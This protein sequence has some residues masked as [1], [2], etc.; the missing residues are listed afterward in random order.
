MEVLLST[1]V[2]KALADALWL[3][4]CN[5]HKETSRNG[6][7]LVCPTPV[8]TV[9]SHPTQRVLFSPL[10]NANPFFHLM[11][12][13]WMI[14]GRNDLDWPLRFNKNFAGFSDD[15]VT[16]HGAYGH[17]WRTHFGID[18][19]MVLAEELT[20]NPNSRRAVLGMWDVTQDLGRDGKDVPCNTHVYFD[21]RNHRLNM[22]VCCRSNDI[23]W[24]AY[25]ANAVHFSILQEF[26]AAWVGIPVGVYRQMSNNLH[27]YTHVLSESKIQD[28]VLDA[29]QND[30]YELGEVKTSPLVRVA[31]HHW[32]Q[33]LEAFL[34]NPLNVEYEYIDPFFKNTAVPMYMAWHHRKTLK[35]SGA[36]WAASIEAEDWR[37]ACTAWITRKEDSR[38]AS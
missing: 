33:D 2:N 30:L 5:G 25:G 32:L 31:I 12:A 1:N 6:P 17:R 36:A 37:E 24:G 18:Q 20:R 13:L 3:V 14:G 7:V 35:S 34:D 28:M 4:K 8:T 15:G 27:L 22:T 9:Y 21:A 16:L 11:E 26:L 29:S 38:A 23:L 10:R 19:L